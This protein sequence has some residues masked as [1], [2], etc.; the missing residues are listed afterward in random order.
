MWSP[1]KQ[2]LSM[3]SLLHHCQCVTATYQKMWMTRLLATTLTAQLFGNVDI[4]MSIHTF[5]FECVVWLVVCMISMVSSYYFLYPN[6]GKVN[7]GRLEISPFVCKPLQA[8]SLRKLLGFFCTGSKWINYTNVTAF[9][10]FTQPI[11]I[12]Q[13]PYIGTILPL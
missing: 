11:F 13:A 8:S 3:H 10:C 1:L 12:T 6:V 5:V 7:V 4:E 2:V 9:S